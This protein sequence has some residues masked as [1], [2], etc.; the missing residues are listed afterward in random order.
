MCSQEQAAFLTPTLSDEPP[1][2]WRDSDAHA[3]SSHSALLRNCHATERRQTGQRGR[4]G[5]SLIL[6]GLVISKSKRRFE[7]HASFLRQMVNTDTCL[8]YSQWRIGGL[9]LERLQIHFAA[10]CLMR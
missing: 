4:K 7:T 9:H 1:P 6:V 3:P 8:H 2:S 5:E 10:V